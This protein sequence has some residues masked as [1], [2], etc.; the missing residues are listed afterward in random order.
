LL[1]ALPRWPRRDLPSDVI[2]AFLNSSGC[3]SRHGRDR[4][5][6]GGGEQAARRPRLDLA[7]RSAVVGQERNAGE[8]CSTSRGSPGSVSPRP[9]CS[10]LARRQ[11][12]GGLLFEIGEHGLLVFNDLSVLLGE[13]G[14][15][16]PRIFG[17]MRELFDGELIRQV[18]TEV[19]SACVGRARSGSSARSPRLSTC[20]TSSY[21]ERSPTTGFRPS[22]SRKNARPAVRVGERRAPARDA[23]HHCR[24]VEHF[25]ADLVLP[26]RS[27][28][29]CRW[30]GSPR[31]P[32]DDRDPVPVAR[33]PGLLPA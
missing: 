11:G 19:A 13:H 8:H 14:S 2:E 3:R 30:T 1:Y 33:C 28:C 18:G 24:D 31:R 22:A 7:R 4:A 12:T 25:F 5:R 10:A 23:R 9:D 20:S 16:R 32:G 17:L 26:A 29:S 21:G 27:R 15:T 6:H